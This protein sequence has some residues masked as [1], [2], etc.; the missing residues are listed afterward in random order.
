M[1]NYKRRYF[2]TSYQGNLFFTVTLTFE[3]LNPPLR[4]TFRSYVPSVLVKEI[5]FLQATRSIVGWVRLATNIFP[6][7]RFGAIPNRLNLIRHED[8]E[9]LLIVADVSQ[10][11]YFGWVIHGQ[12][13]RNK[14]VS[15]SHR[16]GGG[17]KFEARYGGHLDSSKPSF[18]HKE[19]CNGSCLRR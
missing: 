1:S 18:S 17:C 4:Q 8:M 12:L 9:T 14:H 10:N 3:T 7:T 19:R 15:D 5:L 2:A 13:F 6:L 16:R 11:G